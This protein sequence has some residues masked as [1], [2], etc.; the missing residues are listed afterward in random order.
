M[1]FHFPFENTY[2]RLPDRF[3]ARVAPTPVAAPL[4]IR[5]TL[6]ADAMFLVARGLSA[7]MFSAAPD[8][9]AAS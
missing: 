7:V 3:Y 5:L 1:T 2:A 4:L 9:L 8:R 6:P